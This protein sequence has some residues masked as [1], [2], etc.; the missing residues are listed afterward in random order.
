MEEM[1]KYKVGDVLSWGY[2]HT[3]TVQSIRMKK[4][5]FKVGDKVVAFNYDHPNRGRHF[6]V[7]KKIPNYEISCSTTHIILI[8][9]KTEIWSECYLRKATKLD[10]V[11][12]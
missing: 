3:Y 11:L 1:P 2:D 8:N 12:I 10:I 4:S 9:N 5:P 7:V 6:G